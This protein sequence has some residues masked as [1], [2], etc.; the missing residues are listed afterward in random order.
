MFLQ[1]VKTKVAKTAFYITV[2]NG[3][4][5]DVSP[6]HPVTTRPSGQ[7][8]HRQAHIATAIA[9]ATTTSITLLRIGCA[10][11]EYLFFAIITL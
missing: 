1:E 11:L 8:Q 10:S 6:E 3:L 4:K 9:F 5:Q 2:L 7:F